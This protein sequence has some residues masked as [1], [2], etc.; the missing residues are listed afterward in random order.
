MD[1]AVSFRCLGGR[2]RSTRFGS[3]LISTWNCLEGYTL[4]SWWQTV[5]C[6]TTH[7]MPNTFSAYSIDTRVVEKRILIGSA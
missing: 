1:V 5:T 2:G 6:Q 7:G 4:G 3:W